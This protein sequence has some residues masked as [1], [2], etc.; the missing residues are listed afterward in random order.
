MLRANASSVPFHAWDCTP[1][2]HDASPAKVLAKLD[3]LPRSSVDPIVRNMSYREWL[4]DE[5][6]ERW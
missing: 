3:Q 4:T 2:L 1:S 6:A 5:A